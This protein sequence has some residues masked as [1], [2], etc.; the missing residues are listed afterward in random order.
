MQRSLIN[1]ILLLAVPVTVWACEGECISGVTNAWR[2]N[3]T[4]PVH[5]VFENIVTFIP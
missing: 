4:S 3:Y 2:T 1:A 5:A